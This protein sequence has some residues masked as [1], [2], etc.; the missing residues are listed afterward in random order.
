[1]KETLLILYCQLLKTQ[2]EQ[3]IWRL[4]HSTEKNILSHDL[5]TSRPNLRFKLLYWIK[6]QSKN[7]KAKIRILTAQRVLRQTLK[8]STQ[9]SNHMLLSTNLMAFTHLLKKIKACNRQK[10]PFLK[11]WYSQLIVQQHSPNTQ[12]L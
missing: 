3:L 6:R 1:M 9:Y 2:K 11:M 8:P 4:L 10:V 7:R 5:Q 12:F